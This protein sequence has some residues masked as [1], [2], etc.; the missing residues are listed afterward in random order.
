Q[1][2][3]QARLLHRV[4]AIGQPQFMTR[5]RIVL[6]KLQILTARNLTVSYPECFQENPMA[7]SLVVEAKIRW[8]FR[9]DRATA[10]NQPA[11]YVVPDE[12]R[13][14]KVRLASER[15]LFI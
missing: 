6:H 9:I 12:L 5:I 10:L 11:L 13:N 8:I 2:S 3:L 15:R 7:R 4:P 1:R 14:R